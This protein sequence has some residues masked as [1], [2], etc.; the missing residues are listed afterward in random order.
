MASVNL[1]ALRA[2]AGLEGHEL[3]V[4]GVT[5]V[6]PPILPLGVVDADSQDDALAALFGEDVDIDHLK[7]NLSMVRSDRPL[8]EFDPESPE[9]DFDLICERLYGIRRREASGPNREARRD[10]AKQQKKDK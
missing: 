7:A 4:G 5:Y 9:T 10:R 1:D 2:E 6:L 8:S 3:I